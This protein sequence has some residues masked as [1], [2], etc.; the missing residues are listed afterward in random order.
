M[1]P[2][3]EKA[4]VVVTKEQEKQ[5]PVAS[6]T[7]ST[8]VERY[9][10]VSMTVDSPTILL[11]EDPKNIDSKML[12]LSTNLRLNMGMVEGSQSFQA[13]AEN[14]RMFATHYKSR[15]ANPQRI[16]EPFDLALQYKHASQSGRHV[17]LTVTD[18]V[19]SITPSGKQLWLWLQNRKTLI[20]PQKPN[21]TKKDQI[22]PLKPVKTI[23]NCCCF[24]LKTAV[25]LVVLNFSDQAD[26]DDDGR[27]GQSELV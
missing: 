5:K 21:Q 1:T 6:T 4:A 24:T 13:S 18:I 3:K 23:Q 20:R 15:S 2:L 10:V 9:M 26:N 19:I 25:K 22:K 27:I 17:G 12:L 7:N 14:L 11:I 16:L 8:A